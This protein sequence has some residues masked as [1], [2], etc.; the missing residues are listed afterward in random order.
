V[1]AE[2]TA[3]KSPQEITVS[4]KVGVLRDR[5]VHWLWTAYNALNKTDIV[6]KVCCSYNHIIL[7]VLICNGCLG[8]GDVSRR[9]FQ[10]IV[11]KSDKP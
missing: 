8:M 10:P 11:Q 7:L 1:L 3:G 6:K 2:L 5:T 9:R 4:K